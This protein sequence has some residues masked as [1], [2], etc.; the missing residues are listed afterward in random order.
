MTIQVLILVDLQND[1]MPG[2]ALAVPDGDAV[3]AVAN[4]EIRRAD[5]VVATQDWHPEGHGSFASTH[6]GKVPGDSVNLNNLEQILWPDHCIADSN[7]AAFHSGL[8]TSKIDHVVKKGVDPGVDSYSGFFDNDHKTTTGLDTYLR[9]LA[10]TADHTLQPIHLTVM[11]L[12]TDYCVKF[13]VL[14]ACTLGYNVTVRRSG[15]RGVG[16]ATG[17]IAQAFQDMQA[18]GAKLA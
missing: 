10:S 7:G 5:V 4:D 14:D 18:A 2:G 12:A 1:F 6:P 13:T 9:S 15:C 8:E 11:G 3:I 16:L 17:D